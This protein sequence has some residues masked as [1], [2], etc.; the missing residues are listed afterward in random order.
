MVEMTVEVRDSL[1]PQIQS[2]GGWL[3]TIIELAAANFKTSATQKSSVELID[4][5]SQNPSPAEVLNHSLSAEA[6]ARVSFLLDLNRESEANEDDQNELDEWIKFEHICIL[7]TA[8][9]AKETKAKM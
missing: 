6:Q 9:A 1:A 4:F 5:L 3:S 8:K 7:L 2:F